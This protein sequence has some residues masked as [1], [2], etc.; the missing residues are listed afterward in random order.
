MPRKNNPSQV[1]HF[2]A[3]DQ[4]NKFKKFWNSLFYILFVY[5]K[6][7]LFSELSVVSCS[8]FPSTFNDSLQS[9]IN[10]AIEFRFVSNRFSLFSLSFVTKLNCPRDMCCAQRLYL[11][12]GGFVL[13][14]V[15]GKRRKVWKSNFVP[16]SLS[17]K[18]KKLFTV[19]QRMHSDH[20]CTHGGG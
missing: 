17:I 2:V 19:K 3:F 7:E 18:K 16:S 10:F 1:F 15:E 11:K 9:F 14:A 12:V 13:F 5:N 4:S 8:K 6:F 20:R